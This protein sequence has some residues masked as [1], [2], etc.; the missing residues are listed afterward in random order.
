[1]CPKTRTQ[2]ARRLWC[3]LAWP[4]AYALLLGG[5]LRSMCRGSF[6]NQ[7]AHDWMTMLPPILL[8]LTMLFLLFI[9]MTAENIFNLLAWH[10][11]CRGQTRPLRRMAGKR[12]RG[13]V[14]F[15]LMAS[16]IVLLLW[17]SA[18]SSVSYFPAYRIKAD[19]PRVTLETVETE[20]FYAPPE[21]TGPSTDVSHSHF[22]LIPDEVHVTSYGMTREPED[23]LSLDYTVNPELYLDFNYY[24]LW[25]EY[26]AEWLLTGLQAE[27]T[28]EL[29]PVTIQNWEEVYAGTDGEYQLLYARQGNTVIYLQYEGRCNL[30]ERFDIISSAIV[31]Y[32]NR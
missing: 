23:W 6:I 10:R 26:L 15:T 27:Q 21:K 13:T 12:G 8:A 29:Q 16:A 18:R 17:G 9:W 11:T 31:K 22:L 32:E 4:T 5:Y 2:L 28:V 3:N 25:S 1:M 24:N 30:L 19:F 7:S 20:A 14:F